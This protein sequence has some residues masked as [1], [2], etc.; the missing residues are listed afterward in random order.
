LN[1]IIYLLNKEAKESFKCRLTGS[2]VFAAAFLESSF[3]PLVLGV[4]GSWR[5]KINQTAMKTSYGWDL[6]KVF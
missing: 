2:G 4:L 5:N 6:V 3:F 1:I